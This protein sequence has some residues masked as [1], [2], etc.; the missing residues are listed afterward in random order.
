MPESEVFDIIVLG[1]GAAGICAAIQAGRLGARVMLVEKQSQLG[2]TTT[3]GGI[4]G[5]QTFF[6]YGQQVIAGIGWELVCRTYQALGLPGPD[7]RLFEPACGRTTTEVNPAVYAA[8]VDAA[9][10]EAGVELRLHTML[11]AIRSVAKGWSLTL[12][13][14]EGLYEATAGVVIDCS[15]DANAFSLA[16]LPVIRPTERQPGTLVLRLTGYDAR[17]IDYS[18][19]QESFDRELAAGRFRSSDTGWFK[20]GIKPLLESYGGNRIHVINA[21]AMDSRGRTQ[22]ELES[23]RI[24][25]QLMQFFRAQPGLEKLVVS[26]FAPEC[27]VR[28]TVQIEGRSSITCDDY[29]SGRLWPDAVCYSFYPIDVHTDDGLDFRPLTKGTLP[30]IP[31]GAMLPRQGRQ[32]LAAGRCIAGD[33]LAFSAYRIQASCMAMGQ[34]AGAAAALAVS[35]KTDVADVDLTALRKALASHGAIVPGI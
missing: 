6:A 2:G 10:I 15:G 9:V 8:I 24:M 30:T 7:G 31:L 1:G 27:G 5:I 23:R 22:A 34:A 4:N 3:T 18:A 32:I 26:W 28:E 35:S 12:C 17:A 29:M 20:G 14:K 25:L 11:G 19:I 21:N 13:G 33:R 16:G